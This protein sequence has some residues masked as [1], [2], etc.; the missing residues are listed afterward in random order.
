[1]DRTAAVGFTAIRMGFEIVLDGTD[2][3]SKDVDEDKL[4]KLGKLTERYCV[5]LQTIA[6]KPE[7]SVSL[8]GKQA[9]GEDDG[10]EREMVW[11]HKI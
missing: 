10:V 3:R 4:E 1:M 8:R 11:G 6:K 2:E 9:G 5:V 7:L